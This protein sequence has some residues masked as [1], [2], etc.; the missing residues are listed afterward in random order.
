M[1]VTLKETEATPAAYPAAPGNLSPAA[2]ALDAAPIWQRIEAYCRMRWT[3]REVVWT[4]EGGDAWEPPLSPANVTEI[5]VWENGSWVRC[6]PAASPWG[7]YELPG[8]AYR[9]TAEVGSG[10]VPAVVS[11]AF[12]R[13]AEY[14]ADEPDRSAAS[15][16]SH[17]VPGVLEETYE[18]NPAW[19]ARA[20]ELSGAADLLRPYKRRA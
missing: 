5:E 1:A 15:S 13:L 12:R 6:T 3:L 18:R 19:I 7:D 2:A 20:M 10:D 14:L 16:F 11:E 8:F 9:V 4:V 17:A